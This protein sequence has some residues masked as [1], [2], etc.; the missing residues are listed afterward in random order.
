MLKLLSGSEI[1]VFSDSYGVD[2]D[3]IVFS[4]GAENE[5]GPL[6]LYSIVSV[7]LAVVELSPGGW[8]RFGPEPS[9]GAGITTPLS[10]TVAPCPGVGLYS[11]SLAPRQG[12][13]G[14][15]QV[16]AHGYRIADDVLW[17]F[18]ELPKP[19]AEFDIASIP[20]DLLDGSQSEAVTEIGGRP[21]P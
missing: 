4:V 14:D 20:V 16:R 8:P 11:V 17:F 18:F 7:P 21:D 6:H 9:A 10:P 19:G 1:R 13:R 5:D 3:D 12:H 15:I 2:D